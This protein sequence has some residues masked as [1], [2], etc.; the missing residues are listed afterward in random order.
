MIILYDY[1]IFDLKKIYIIC[2]IDIE[3][4]EIDIGY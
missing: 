2:K 3:N 1:I 4:L